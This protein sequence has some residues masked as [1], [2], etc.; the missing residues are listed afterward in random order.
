MANRLVALLAEGVGR[1]CTSKANNRK[2]GA[3][4][5]LAEGVG[6]NTHA[7]C[8]IT[9]A[10][11]ALLAE[12]VGRNLQ[13]VS[14]LLDGQVAL[15]AEGVGRNVRSSIWI[16]WASASP[17]SRRAWVEIYKLYDII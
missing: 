5:L 11:V 14:H 9:Y 6:R 2:P 8:I 1:N 16:W 13:I 3:V 7:H 10:A 15:L 4:A 12:G 17:S